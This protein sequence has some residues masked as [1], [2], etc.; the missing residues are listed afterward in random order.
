MIT[1]TVA[2]EDGEPERVAEDGCLNAWRHRF[3]AG[4][5]YACDL[6]YTH[7]FIVGAC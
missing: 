4:G 3:A 7:W 2:R 5:R 1:N 6:L